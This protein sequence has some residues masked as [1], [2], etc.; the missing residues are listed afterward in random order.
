[1]DRLPKFLSL[2][3]DGE[4]GRNKRRKVETQRERKREGDRDD[5]EMEERNLREGKQSM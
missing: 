3:R 4:R 5:G 2:M 1:M